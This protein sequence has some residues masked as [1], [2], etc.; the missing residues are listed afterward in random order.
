MADRRFPPVELPEM[1]QIHIEISVLTPMQLVESFD[2]IEVGRDG[3]M[4]F[5]G[6]NRGLLLPQ[7]AADYGWDR[8]QF[9]EQTC[10][11]AGL[12]KDAYLAK[13]AIIYKF[14]AVIFGE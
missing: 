14:Q 7:V 3:L 5:K 2:E 9:L 1:K 6:Q 8:T 13:D 4:I 12:N 11:K 10:R